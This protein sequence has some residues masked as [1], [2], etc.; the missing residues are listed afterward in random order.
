MITIGSVA[1]VASAPAVA[2]PGSQPVLIHVRD[3][4]HYPLA[5]VRQVQ[6]AVQYQV[7]HQLQPI[8]HTPR[9]SFDAPSTTEGP[10]DSWLADLEAQDT[11]MYGWFTRANGF[12]LPDSPVYIDI[13]GRDQTLPMSLILSHEVIEALVD[14]RADRMTDGVLTEI[15]DPVEQPSYQ[16]NGITVSNFVTPRWFSRSPLGGRFDFNGLLT[17]PR[18]I[19]PQGFM[20]GS[21]SSTNGASL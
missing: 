17:S 1:G 3:L 18:T 20:P 11:V 10:S 5:Y 4:A 8:W 16:I 15:C 2:S 21:T 9:I 14:P 12:H 13:A 7:N 19:T 6:R